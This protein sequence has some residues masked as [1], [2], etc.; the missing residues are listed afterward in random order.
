VCPPPCLS[1]PRECGAPPPFPL[2]VW[3]FASEIG[4]RRL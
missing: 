4:V 1:L 2:R 3:S